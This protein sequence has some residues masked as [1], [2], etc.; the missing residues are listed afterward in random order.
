MLVVAEEESDMTI[1]EDHVGLGNNVYMTL[2]VSEVKVKEGAHIHHV[3]VQ[4]DSEE[5]VHVS[6]PIAS[7]E[8]NSKYHAYTINLGAR[9]SRIEHRVVHED[10]EVYFILAG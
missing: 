4:R 1:V 8:K 2:P 10:D 9:L 6:R 5:A 7:V 3:R